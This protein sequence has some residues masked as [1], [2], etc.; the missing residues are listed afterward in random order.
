M[1]SKTSR[2][3]VFGVHSAGYNPAWQSAISSVVM[4]P[5]MLPK[6]R[7]YSVGPLSGAYS[8]VPAFHDEPFVQRQA[9]LATSARA[10]T[11]GSLRQRKDRQEIACDK[12]ETGERREPWKL[13]WLV[14]QLRGKTRFCNLGENLM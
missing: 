4:S 9:L 12:G 13:F 8:N 7:V 5:K 10:V 6:P 1:E 11:P 14:N 3:T 2:S